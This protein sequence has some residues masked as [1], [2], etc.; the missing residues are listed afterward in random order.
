MYARSLRLIVSYTPNPSGGKVAAEVADEGYS[1]VLYG[2]ER[3]HEIE[4]RERKILICRRGKSV[5]PQTNE[6]GTVHS[7][8]LPFKR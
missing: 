4:P 7:I 1:T 3:A 2:F 6:E 8:L 5:L